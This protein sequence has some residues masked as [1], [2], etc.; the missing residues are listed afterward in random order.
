MNSVK[1]RRSQKT[2]ACSW[3]SFWNPRD[4]VQ[5]YVPDNPKSTDTHS[6]HVRTDLWQD[7][8]GPCLSGLGS[9]TLFQV[10]LSN[11]TLIPQLRSLSMQRDQRLESDWWIFTVL[12]QHVLEGFIPPTV[13][14]LLQGHRL[15][16]S[17]PTG[18][19]KRIWSSLFT[20]TIQCGG[21]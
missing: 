16:S 21:L 18:L 3:H 8:C 2:W 12:D 9:F 11:I 7:S 15:S 1:I 14:N 13:R 5:D 4:T 17:V 6:S 10:G 19:L 20:I